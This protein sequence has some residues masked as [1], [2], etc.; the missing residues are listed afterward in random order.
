MLVD[1]GDAS[2]VKGSSVF[3]DFSVL[4]L[5]SVFWESDLRKLGASGGFPRLDLLVCLDSTAGRG[6][7]PGS[8]NGDMP[9][10]RDAARMALPTAKARPALSCS[11]AVAPRAISCGSGASA[12]AAHNNFRWEVS[13]SL[14]QNRTVS[15]ENCLQ[16]ARTPMSW[17]LM[18]S[19][20]SLL[21]SWTRS[22][23]PPRAESSSATTSF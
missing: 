17:G 23:W 19:P 13:T 20:A 2:L 3:S 1:L 11:A 10:L 4:S 7:S 9:R 5:L 21:A 6:F 22:S 14:R 15:L 12:K 18:A 8:D 16:V